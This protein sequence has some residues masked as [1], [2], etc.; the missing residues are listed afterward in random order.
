[1]EYELDSPY[2]FSFFSKFFY[3][4]F[5]AN[6]LNE[7]IKNTGPFS[8]KRFPVEKAFVNGKSSNRLSLTEPN[9][10][11]NTVDKSINI[12]LLAIAKLKMLDFVNIHPAQGL[13]TTNKLCGYSD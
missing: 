6:H 5:A 2:S 10:F 9:V 8:L 4:N 3:L 13:T 7:T 1:M 12:L 11:D